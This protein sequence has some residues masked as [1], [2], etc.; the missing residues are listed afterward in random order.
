MRNRRKQDNPDGGLPEVIWKIYLSQLGWT[1]V[2]VG[3]KL[4]FWELPKGRL[5]VIVPQHA[6]AVIDGC[7]FDTFDSW[8]ARRMVRGYWHK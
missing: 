3:Q 1:W 2:P 7:V 8:R 6:I 4:H 5:V